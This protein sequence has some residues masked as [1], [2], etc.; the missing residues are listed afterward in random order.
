VGASAEFSLRMWRKG[1][2]QWVELRGL[3]TLPWQHGN[4]VSWTWVLVLST[5][6]GEDGSFVLDL[7]FGF[8]SSILAPSRVI[9]VSLEA[10]GSIAVFSGRVD[11]HVR[12]RRWILD[13]SDRKPSCG[14]CVGRPASLLASRRCIF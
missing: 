1:R 5:A 8:P 4:R 14:S 10:L 11:V 9:G 3:E 13:Q 7:L 2:G 6:F 12:I